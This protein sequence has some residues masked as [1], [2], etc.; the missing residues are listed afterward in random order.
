MRFDRDYLVIVCTGGHRCRLHPVF[1][2]VG[3]AKAFD[4][5]CI[6]QRQWQMIEEILATT[7]FISFGLGLC[8]GVWIARKKE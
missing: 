4:V 1:R 7:A 6:N 8:L 5:R 3:A 2:D